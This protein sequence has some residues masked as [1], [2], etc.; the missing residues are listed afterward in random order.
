M[1]ESEIIQPFNFV[2]N[3]KIHSNDILIL[4]TTQLFE[5][6][7]TAYTLII[8]YCWIKASSNLD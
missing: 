6:Q 2:D 7:Y 8:V 3:K 5:Y 4:L 1:I